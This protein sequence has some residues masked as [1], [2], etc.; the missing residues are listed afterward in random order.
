M[1]QAFHRHGLDDRN[2]AA[3]NPLDLW[4]GQQVVHFGIQSVLRYFARRRMC[5][6]VGNVQQP[7]AN[8]AVRDL[9][10]QQQVDLVK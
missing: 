5:S 10:V 8:L 6:G 4:Q 9:N 1:L 2:H 7:R 3:R